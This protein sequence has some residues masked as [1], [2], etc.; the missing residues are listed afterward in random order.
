MGGPTKAISLGA[1]LLILVSVGLVQ[2]VLSDEIAILEQE[3]PINH[4]DLSSEEFRLWIEEQENKVV[5]K[6]MEKISS[7]NDTS[8]QHAAKIAVAKV[9]EKLI[10]MR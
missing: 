6:I 2:H 9:S 3:Q 4:A 8:M 7:P 5:Y 1:H 10:G